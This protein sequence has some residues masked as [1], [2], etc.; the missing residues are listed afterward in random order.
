MEN[1]PSPRILS[2]LYG[3]ICPIGLF[4]EELKGLV[5]VSPDFFAGFS[6]FSSVLPISSLKINTKHLY[7]ITGID[8]C[9]KAKIV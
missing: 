1:P 2:S 5:G 6:F 3:P 9:K 4:S 7:I 8:A